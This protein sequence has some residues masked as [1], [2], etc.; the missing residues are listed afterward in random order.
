MD[1]H[2]LLLVSTGKEALNVFP[3]HWEICAL[4]IPPLM[5]KLSSGALK[6]W[7]FPCFSAKSWATEAGQGLLV[8]TDV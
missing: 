6:K 1:L 3:G 4:T 2:A 8:M 7:V 5:A